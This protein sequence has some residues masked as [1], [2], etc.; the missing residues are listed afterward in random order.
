MAVPRGAAFSFY[1]II[2]L[3]FNCGS[4]QDLGEFKL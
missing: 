4:V 1:T 3:M 2:A